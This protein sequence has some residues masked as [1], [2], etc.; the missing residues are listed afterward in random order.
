MMRDALE[1]KSHRGFAIIV[2]APAGTGKTTLVQMLI[3]EFPSEFVQSISCTTRLP[4]L[5]EVE[6]KHYLF[7]DEEEFQAR[8]DRKE[9][10]EHAQVFGH[11][12]GTLKKTVERERLLGKHVILV[13][14]TQ[15]A[16]A[17]KESLDALFVFIKPPSIGVLKERLKSRKTEAE[18]IIRSRLESARHE[19]ERA[20]Y[21]DYVIT[22][23]HL[24]TAYE[25]LKSIILA[26]IQKKEA[27]FEK[28]TDKGKIQKD[29]RR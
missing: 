18:G 9:F 15:G 25:V 28:R 14:D 7:L 27:Y 29:F 24:H 2:S 26:E 13:I 10:L 1:G 21:Y 17:L 3:N 12:Y 16:L 5:G 19:I 8:V 6:G 4:R 20:V 22:N 11:R 23:D